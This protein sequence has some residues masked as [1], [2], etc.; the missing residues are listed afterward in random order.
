[1]DKRYACYCGIYCENCAVKVKV[2]PAAKKLYDEMKS[3]GFEEVI[4]YIPGGDGFWPFLKGMAEHG[5]CVSCRDGSGNPACSV[6]ACAKEKGAEMCALCEDYPCE[7]IEE[8]YQNYPAYRQDNELLRRE[9]W[10]A[11]AAL[12]DERA[13]RRVG[14]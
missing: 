3:A 8:F 7:T 1:M 13:E 11:W 9:G 4:D 6:R 14:S 10:A 12:Q 5:I 2:E